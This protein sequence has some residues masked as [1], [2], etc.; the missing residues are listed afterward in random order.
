M[1]TK[2]KIKVLICA[3]AC[4]K[5]P[6]KKY[7]S[8]AGGE[9]VLGWNVILQLSRFFDISVLTHY[10]NKE[11]IEKK[12]SGDEL[13]GI[14]FYYINLPPFLNFTRKRI[15]IYTYLWQ[16][17]SYFFAKKLYQ[18]N[19]FDIFHHV[20]YSND[21]MAS[22][23]GALLPIPYIRG[24]GGGAHRVPTA[25]VKEY[26]FKQ[27]A[28]E[29]I[30][31]MGQWVFRQDPFFAIGQNKA[32]AI[33]VCN[34]EAF[35][36]LPQKWQV[37]AYFFPVNGILKEDLSLFKGLEASHDNFLI[38]TT[39]KLIKIKGFDL[40]IRAFKIFSDRV[41]IAQL[42]IV[43][44]GSELKILKKIVSKLSLE[45][46]VVFEGWMPKEKL[47]KE[48]LSCDIFLFP[49]LRDGGGQVVVEAMAASKPVVCFDNAGPGFYIDEKCGIKIKSENPG[50]A[51]RDMADALEK[52]YYNKELRA[53]LGKGAREKVEKEY[54]WDKLGDKL[55]EIY[56]KVL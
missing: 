23:I 20:T 50:Q 29:K 16:I 12:L 44:D 11:A 6:D 4:L 40:A 43:G 36:A 55:N 53:D 42:V 30:R 49:S 17:K 51:V 25:F 45:E 31:S 14:K 41:S 39:G 54:S 2:N 7:S 34:Y 56:K 38:L 1:E 22:F 28:T 19:H 9:T 5:D 8:M 47:L 46:K 10:E 18:K 48:M 37:K 15:Q 21:W 35:D 52:L 24:P 33:L 13:R 3:F 32:K 27:R 26:S